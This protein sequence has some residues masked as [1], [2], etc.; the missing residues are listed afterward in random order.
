[1]THTG[2]CIAITWL[3]IDFYSQDDISNFPEE[4]EHRAQTARARACRVHS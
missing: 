2:L 4:P 1:M 3:G